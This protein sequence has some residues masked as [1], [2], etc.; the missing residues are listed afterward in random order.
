MSLRQRNQYSRLVG[1]GGIGSGIFFALDGNH[2]LGRNESRAARLIEVRD[3]CKLHIISHY[4]AVLLNDRDVEFQVV[5]VAKVGNDS[6]GARLIDELK[7]AGVITNHITI[8]EGAPTLSS[9]C[10]QY[11]DGSGG[12]ITA[13]NSAASML[14][15]A[16]VNDVAE[17]LAE[18]SSQCIALALPEVPLDVRHCLLKLATPSHSLRVASFTSTEV[19]PAKA[20]RIFECVDLLFLNQDEAATLAESSFDRSEP[21]SI[22]NKCAAI[23][24]TI[25]PRIRIVVTAGREGAFALEHDEWIH[26][27]AYQAD[28]KST[29]GAGDALL[30]GTLV[31]LISGLPLALGPRDSRSIESALDFGVLLGSYSTTSPHTIHPNARFDDVLTFAKH[32]GVELHFNHLPVA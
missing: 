13:N 16:N 2:D 28:V 20:K 7:S 14:T 9:V 24:R 32:A 10:Y 1:V 31:G 21:L 19:L 4:L 3:Y 17:L 6:T 18:S 26:R 8:A 11:P 12:N 29:A 23:L 5:P 30:A 25:Q 27:P 15:P 22:L